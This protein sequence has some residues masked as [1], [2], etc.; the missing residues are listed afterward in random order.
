M[1][2]TIYTSPIKALSNQ[3]FRDFKVSL[4]QLFHTKSVMNF[5]QKCREKRLRAMSNSSVINSIREYWLAGGCCGVVWM[6][7]LQFKPIFVSG[8]FWRCWPDHW[9]YPNQSCGDLP[10]HDDW[11]S[12]FH[13]LQRKWHD[14]R[15]WIRH[16]WRGKQWII[17]IYKANGRFAQHIL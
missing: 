17:L 8:T 9:R 15:P 4:T 10:H 13:A 2:K 14:Q 1:T 7:C 12:S 16:F 5:V 6:L 11:N 3:K